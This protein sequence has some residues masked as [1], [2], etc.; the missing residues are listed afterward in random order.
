[1]QH[2]AGIARSGHSPVVHLDMHGNTD[3]LK[4]ASSEVLAWAEFAPLLIE[5]NRASRMNLLVVAAACHGWHMT[6]I[7]RPTDRA[8]AWGII[9][10]PDS[11]TAG[12]L[13]EA[14]KRFYAT[15]L[16]TLDLPTPLN[17]F[18]AI[19]MPFFIT[20]RERRA[21]LRHSCTTPQALTFF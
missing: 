6:D 2:I 16:A 11:V 14:T 20:L 19:R 3:G 15:L 18:S 17:P 7:L 13:Y 9:G 8:P 10:P 5:I 4:V 21:F 12:E 1:L